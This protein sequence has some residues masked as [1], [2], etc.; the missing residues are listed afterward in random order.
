MQKGLVTRVVAD[1]EVEQ[2]AYASARRIADG[3]PLVA[4]WH[5]Q[6]MRRQADPTPL[7][8]QEKDAS[9]LCYD[10]EDFHIGYNSFLDKTKPR[11]KGK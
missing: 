3:A 7:S 11:F 2:E 1:E 6:F 5:K 4:R 8:E 10:T 9:Y